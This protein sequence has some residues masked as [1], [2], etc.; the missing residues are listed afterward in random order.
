MALS[1]VGWEVAGAL[2]N[3]IKEVCPT[4]HVVAEPTPCPSMEAT[5]PLV[6][7]GTSCSVM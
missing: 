3:I 5:Y 1:L 6:E 7:Q 2:V 4:W